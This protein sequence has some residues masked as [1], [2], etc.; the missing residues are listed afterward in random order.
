MLRE[1]E[2]DGSQ[3]FNE[4]A[5]LL[6]DSDRIARMERGAASIGAPD[7]KKLIQKVILDILK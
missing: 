1:K 3:L 6:S 4:A 2:I 5:A 7:S